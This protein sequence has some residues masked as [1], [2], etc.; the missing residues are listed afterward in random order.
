MFVQIFKIV[1]YYFIIIYYMVYYLIRI[2]Q[3]FLYVENRS[4]LYEV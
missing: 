4:H 1:I 2:F 3:V